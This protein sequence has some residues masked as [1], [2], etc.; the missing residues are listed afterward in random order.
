MST[1]PPPSELPIPKGQANKSSRDKALRE[2][3]DAM[4][5]SL[6]R[7]GVI[8]ADADDATQQALVRIWNSPDHLEKLDDLQKNMGYFICM[9]RTCLLSALRTEKAR[10]AREER[11]FREHPAS[12]EDSMQPKECLADSYK[13]AGLTPTQVEYLNLLIRDGLS[14]KEIAEEKGLTVRSVNYLV[15][16]AVER[17]RIVLASQTPVP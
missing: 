9:G 16:R 6:I 11:Y 14:M 12:I 2:V 17:L 15:R 13:A 4:F 10:R 8:T 5:R 1:A 7:S 3:R